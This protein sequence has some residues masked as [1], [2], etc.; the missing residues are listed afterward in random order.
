[1]PLPSRYDLS[2][3]TDGH[4]HAVLERHVASRRRFDALPRKHDA[5]RIEATLNAE[6]SI[7]KPASA[8]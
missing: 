8:A 6:H 3:T 4:L 7:L 5:Q 2:A 1:L